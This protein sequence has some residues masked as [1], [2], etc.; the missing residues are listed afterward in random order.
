MIAGTLTDEF[1][2]WVN[3]AIAA[4]VPMGAGMSQAIVACFGCGADGAVFELGETPETVRWSCP[5]A[6]TTGRCPARRSIVIPD[7]TAGWPG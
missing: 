6:A 5:T 4:A 2:E 7:P 1:V 3:E